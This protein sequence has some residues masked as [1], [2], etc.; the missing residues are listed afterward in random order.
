MVSGE[1]MEMVAQMSNVMYMSFHMSP[2][3]W[4]GGHQQHHMLCGMQT[5]STAAHEQLTPQ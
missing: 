4:D 5:K 2:M 1:M 3:R